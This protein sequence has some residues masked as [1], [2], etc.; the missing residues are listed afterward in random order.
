[1]VGD[2]Y[3]IRRWKKMSNPSFIEML[4]LGAKAS[5][6]R[7]IVRSLAATTKRLQKEKRKT[8]NFIINS[9]DKGEI[10]WKELGKEK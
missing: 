8:Q 5:I 9:L 3:H 1:M 4:S 7:H 2:A 10:K 6:G